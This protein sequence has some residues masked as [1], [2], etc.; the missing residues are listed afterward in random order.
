ML[1]TLHIASLLLAA[2]LLG[3]AACAGEPAGR[4][5]DLLAPLAQ[6]DGGGVW[7]AF[8]EPDA[9]LADVWQLD[10]GILTCKGT[11]KGY[12]Y[13]TKNYTDFILTLE[14]RWPPQGKAGNGGVLLRI[15][16]KDKIWPKS[17]EAQ[18]NAGQAGDFWGLDGYALT[19]PAERLKTADNPQFGKLTNLKK[20][21]AVERTPGEWNQYEITARG[22]TVTLKINGKIVNKATGCAATPGR[23]CL[24]AEGDPIQFR[25]VKLIALDK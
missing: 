20:T 11:P 1:R 6:P 23:I 10:G 21:E 24:T 9:K 17:L 3:T 8:H 16:G 2:G 7:Q 22:D 18:I 15:T 19:G 12:L 14:W 4:E 13:T 25:N 5:I